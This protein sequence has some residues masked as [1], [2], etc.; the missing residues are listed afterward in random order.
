MKFFMPDKSPQDAESIYQGFRESVP[1][2]T[3]NARIY[4]LTFRDHKKEVKAR[5]G[6][7]DPLEGRM[8]NAMLESDECYIIWAA[9]RG[10]NHMMINKR[11]VTGVEKF[12]PPE[13][14]DTPK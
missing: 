12:D 10:Y 4:S 6:F 14:T 3:S 2:N 9:G 5:V 8:V 1:F 11:D 7:P 13:T